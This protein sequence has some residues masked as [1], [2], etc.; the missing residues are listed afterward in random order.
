MIIDLGLAFLEGLA[1]I[2]SPCILPV[3]PLVLAASVEGGKRRPYGIIIGFV[4]A[5]SLFALAS[6]QIVL[7]LGVDLDIIKN[8]SLVLL[9][10]FGLVLLSSK[11]SEKFS[12]MT[13]GAANFG[14]DLASRGGDGLLSGILIGALI[15]LVWTPCAGPILAAVLVQVIRQ[16]T[17][18]AGNLIIVSFA[19]GAGVPMF[20][21]A[22]TGRKM[23]NKLGFLTR[24]AEAVRRGFGVL[25]LLSVAYIASG[26]DVESLLTTQSTKAQLP[27]GELV[28]QDGLSTPYAAPEFKEIEAW[29]NA[30]PLTMQSLKGKVVLIDFW[31]YSCINCVR[32]LPYITDWDS[33]YRDHGLVIVGVHSPEFEFEKKLDNVK[34]AIAQHGIRYPVAQDNRLSTWLNFKNRYWP[35]HYLIDRDG[36]VVYTHFGEGKYDVTEN[37][38]RYLLGLKNGG[39]TVKASAPAVNPEQTAE[40]YLGYG[41]ANSYDGDAPAMHDKAQAY[42]FPDP[43]AEDGWALNGKWKVGAENI[44]ALENGAALRL[45][46]NAR[47]VFLVLGTSTGKPIKV[48]IRLNGEAVGLNAGKEAPG[49]VVTVERNTLY[50]LIDQKIPK[51]GVLEIQSDSPGLEA[52]AFTFG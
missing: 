33:K 27:A 13:Q 15:G 40:T 24:H 51:K 23:M 21:I 2:A 18:L 29:V 37:N 31:T 47:K 12:S 50:E 10:L 9:A 46:F 52:Y 1:L 20:I 39:A 43:L 8:V 14:N 41:R 17:A 32:T 7:A 22:M 45:D 44:T 48:S 49:G 11:L 26:V 38:I 35:A 42:R 4:L 3:L 6:R 5:F 28:L 16:E 36:K 25:I 19:L 34:A 30:N